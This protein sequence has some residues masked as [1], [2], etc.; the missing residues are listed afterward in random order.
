MGI[1]PTD[2]ESEIAEFR[3]WFRDYGP[4]LYL[5][6]ED[7]K[8]A[9]IDPSLIWSVLSLDDED[10]ISNCFAE[11]D[12]CYGFYIATKPYKADE[13]TLFVT[14]HVNVPCEANTDCDPDCLTCGGLG[15]TTIDIEEL[16]KD[17]PS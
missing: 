7:S 2:F 16:S 3:K 9:E 13:G 8:I 14:T 1:D 17:S 4:Y 5:E 11:D 10:Y 6:F 15:N 12:E